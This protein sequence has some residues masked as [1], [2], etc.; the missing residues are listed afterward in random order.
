MFKGWTLPKEVVLFI[1]NQKYAY[2]AYSDNKSSLDAGK[3]W[4]GKEGNYVKTANKDFKL[5]ILKKNSCY[6]WECLIEK[7]ADSISAIVVLN[8]DLLNNLI[9]Q[10]DFKHGVCKQKV[11]LARQKGTV[12]A[13]HKG[14]AEYIDAAKDMQTK[15]TTRVKLTTK[16]EFGHIYKTPTNDKVGDICLGVYQ[17]P[18]EKFNMTVH[19]PKRFNNIDEAGLDKTDIDKI[20]SLGSSRIFDITINKKN[21]AAL[22]LQ[23]VDDRE[24][25]TEFIAV[26]RCQSVNKGSRRID[27]G[28]SVLSDEQ[29]KNIVNSREFAR[30]CNNNSVKTAS[31]MTTDKVDDEY[32]KLFKDIFERYINIWKGYKLPHVYIVRM[33]DGVHVLYDSKKAVEFIVDQLR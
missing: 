1:D 24:D 29:L 32:L 12:G 23:D 8:E 21:K 25:L 19:N 15:D 28:H 30:S 16:R 11:S 33:S 27:C 5:T 14:M 31:V 3:R 13:L 6:G 10:S 9:I 2:V 7:E 20:N 4:V 17:T 18:V 26:S 22:M